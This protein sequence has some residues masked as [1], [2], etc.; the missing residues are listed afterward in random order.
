MMVQM[1]TAAV[2]HAKPP[3]ERTARWGVE[4]KGIVQ[5]ERMEEGIKIWMGPGETVELISV[6]LDR[7]ADLSRELPQSR[8][9][10][11]GIWVSSLSLVGPDS[12]Y[13]GAQWSSTSQRTRERASWT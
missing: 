8:T 7:S 12:E 10:L 2:I 5:E 13:D 3:G 6:K 11:R 9:N 1:A 4:G